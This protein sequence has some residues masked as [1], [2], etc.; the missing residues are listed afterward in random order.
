MK[1]G[2]S[3]N[4]FVYCSRPANKWMGDVWL[5]SLWGMEGIESE[6]VKKSI[7][8]EASVHLVMNQGNMS[9]AHDVHLS[10]SKITLSYLF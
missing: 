1:F 3:C 9:Y 2:D 4:A 10:D 7:L 8:F 6:A 5:R